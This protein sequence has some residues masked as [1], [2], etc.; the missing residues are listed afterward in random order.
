[1]LRSSYRPWTYAA[2]LANVEAIGVE[3]QL[4]GLPVARIP[5]DLM[6]RA[7]SGD[8]AATAQVGEFVRMVRDLR[9]NEQAGV[10]LPSDPHPSPDGSGVTSTPMYD[11]SLLSAAGTGTAGAA[12]IPIRRHRADI[13][14]A[15]LA[16]FIL[17]GQQATGS[18]ALST[19]KTDLFLRALQAF[20]SAIEAEAQR[21]IVIP[22]WALNGKDTALRPRLIAGKI[23]RENIEALANYIATLAGAGAR[24]F[25]DTELEN[26]LRSRAGLPPLPQ[27]AIAAA[28]ATE[29]NNDPLASLFG[30]GK[31]QETDE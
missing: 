24:M 3:R 31:Q 8:A 18:W 28:A 23:A 1:M 26:N 22:L 12:D 4:A 17:L 30:D 25:P 19:D 29:A 9:L 5:L 10:V 21:G 27:E 20:L 11:L 15:L 7:A 2:N 16:D 6:A 13:A 14:T